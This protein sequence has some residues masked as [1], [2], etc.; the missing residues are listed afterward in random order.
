MD[1]SAFVPIKIQFVPQIPN[2]IEKKKKKMVRRCSYVSDEV[3][4]EKKMGRF[5][6]SGLAFSASALCIISSEV[7]LI[8]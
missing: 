6:F 5:M 1:N 3:A 8:S 2:L 4:A 7:V